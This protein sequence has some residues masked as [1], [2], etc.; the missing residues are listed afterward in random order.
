MDENISI[1]T[2]SLAI[3]FTKKGLLLTE[4]KIKTPRKEIEKLLTL[5]TITWFFLIAVLPFMKLLRQRCV[6]DRSIW[7]HYKIASRIT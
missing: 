1:K 5:D 3:I 7:K 4:I 2:F 6:H